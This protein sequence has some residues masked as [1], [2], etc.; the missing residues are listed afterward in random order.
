MK[1]VGAQR[2][3]A[4]A[5]G[6]QHA[7]HLWLLPLS[8]PSPCWCGALFQTWILQLGFYPMPEDHPREKLKGHDRKQGYR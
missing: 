1:F 8:G 2:F 4:C 5:M 6:V 3:V 7:F